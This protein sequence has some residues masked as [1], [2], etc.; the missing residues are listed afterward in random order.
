MS[1][2]RVKTSGVK[3]FCIIQ[4]CGDFVLIA[5][6][7]SWLKLELWWLRKACPPAGSI[8]RKLRGSPWVCCGLTSRDVKGKGQSLEVPL[9][10]T[11]FPP[12]RDHRSKL[13][14][15]HRKTHHLRACN[16]LYSPDLQGY[17]GSQCRS[18]P[19]LQSTKH[20]KRGCI[21]HTDN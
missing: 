11:P 19:A 15:K 9:P 20:N 7:Q 18:S 10:P 17:S 12:A 13:G 1:K 4:R 6:W 3:T 2:W 14:P 5:K 21:N 16:V 8:P